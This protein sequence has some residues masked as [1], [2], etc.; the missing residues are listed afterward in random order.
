MEIQYYSHICICGCGRQIEI[1][2]RHKYDGI[3]KYINGH[4]VTK[5]RMIHGGKGSKLYNIWGV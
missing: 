4:N 3:P 2:I 5:G 1:K